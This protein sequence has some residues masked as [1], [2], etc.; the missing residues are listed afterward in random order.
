MQQLGLFP[1]ELLYKPLGNEEFYAVK[2]FFFE[3]QKETYYNETVLSRWDWLKKSFCDVIDSN[4]M[5]NILSNFMVQR[6]LANV[7]QFVLSLEQCLDYIENFYFLYQ[8]DNQVFRLHNDMKI[9]LLSLMKKAMVDTICE[10]GL[11][12]R[13]EEII[14]EFRSDKN[15]LDNLLQKHRYL[16]INQLADAY[17][18]KTN[19]PVGMEV[20]TLGV[21]QKLALEKRL[22]ITQL[23]ELPD[24][25][26]TS[27]S[28]RRIKTYFDNHYAV[29]FKEYES[30]II[31]NVSEFILF[32]FYE[33]LKINKLNI[34][35]WETENIVLPNGYNIKLMSRHRQLSRDHMEKDTI[36]LYLQD[37]YLEGE[38]IYGITKYSAP[39]SLNRT[40]ENHDLNTLAIANLDTNFDEI[41]QLLRVGK[42]HTLTDTFQE[43]LIISLLAERG[44]MTYYALHN[45][46]IMFMNN[47]LQLSS[48]E[49]IKADFFVESDDNLWVLK[50][51][52]E[53][54]KPIKQHVKNI[55]L[56]K[57]YFIQT[58]S[59]YQ[60]DF[61]F[62]LSNLRLK[63]KITIE[64][65][66]EA[67]QNIMDRLLPSLGDLK[68]IDVVFNYPFVLL[69]HLQHNFN[70]LKKLPL[71]YKLNIVFVEEVAQLL[72]CKINAMLK[73]DNEDEIKIIMQDFFDFIE[74]QIEF[75]LLI[76]E[77]VRRHDLICNIINSRTSVKKIQDV[78]DYLSTE[79]TISLNKFIKCTQQISPMQ[80]KAVLQ[81]RASISLPSLPYC[82]DLRLLNQFYTELPL[83]D[84]WHGYLS[85]KRLIFEQQN[86]TRA[87]NYIIA[88]EY[89]FLA[90]MRYQHYYSYFESMNDVSR[91][92][93]QIKL[94]LHNPLNKIV[95]VSL[96]VISILP[97]V[98][99]LVIFTAYMQSSLI[100][101]FDAF[102][103]CINKLPQQK[104]HIFF[105]LCV[106]LALK[107]SKYSYDNPLPLFIDC[108][109]TLPFR[110]NNSDTII[111]L[112]K[113][114][115][116]TKSTQYSHLMLFIVIIFA[117]VLY[118]IA[119][120]I[121]LNYF[122]LF[123]LFSKNNLNFGDEV[124]RFMSRVTGTF[125]S[126]YVLEISDSL[127]TRVEDGIFRLQG[128][129][130]QSAYQKAKCLRQVLDLVA[131]FPSRELLLPIE[132]ARKLDK[133]TTIVYKGSEY[134]TSFWQIASTKRPIQGDFNLTTSNNVFVTP[135]TA[136]YLTKAPFS[137]FFAHKSEQTANSGNIKLVLDRV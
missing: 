27:A 120:I 22:G 99:K 78:I 24:I 7:N 112:N 50:S 85:C 56:H 135:T 42:Q 136:K 86:K 60:D 29:S 130:N 111:F 43:Q 1:T 80:L 75:I 20:H 87:A 55:L 23:Y 82:H 58:S 63:N 17:N 105:D 49:E 65:L 34:T 113:C 97:M 102:K 70:L 62:R 79:R 93:T 40:T 118:A 53:F 109:S 88:T 126:A 32:K 110:Y 45:E 89:W 2:K 15:W 117:I 51:K 77:S 30:N 57:K 116:D 18:T 72:G 122:K 106:N 59:C 123:N 38:Q 10:T 121:C 101:K 91:H 94:S 96:F 44:C 11:F 131:N 13:F 61:N 107:C 132:L 54:L 124:K 31:N 46:I 12:I 19:L 3:Q 71:K 14:I 74:D 100:T 9:S 108:S 76:P 8:N 52:Q 66:E 119:L 37:I 47:Y 92:L 21:M 84:G 95:P 104:Q 115:S 48:I 6:R 26:I 67:S 134:L 36:Y 133:E 81:H 39:F 64:D 114:V 28:I 25:H 69:R 90:Y 98:Y 125:S 129:D 41:K 103:I 4:E 5:Q 137:R 33:L 127:L 35:Q 68:T 128:L 83:L 16:I 73:D